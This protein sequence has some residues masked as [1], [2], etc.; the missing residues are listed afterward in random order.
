MTAARAERFLLLY[1]SHES[2]GGRLQELQLE[3]GCDNMDIDLVT[4][5]MSR[6]RYLLLKREKTEE[7]IKYI[8]IFNSMLGNLLVTLLNFLYLLGILFI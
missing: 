2:S 7:W 4:D 5:S 6:L 3:A 1:Q 8:N